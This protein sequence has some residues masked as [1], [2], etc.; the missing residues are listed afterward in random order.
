MKKLIALTTTLLMTFGTLGS[1][2]FAADSADVYVTISDKDGNLAMAQEKITVTDTDGDGALT[3]NDALHAAHEAKYDGGAAA[4]F[5]SSEGQYGLAIDR[6]WGSANG[7]S[8]G[9]YIN[10]KS[11]MGL[12]DAVNSGDYINA[13]VFTDL[14]AWSDTYCFFDTNTLNGNTNEDLALTLSAAG[15]DAGWNP[16]TLPVEGA[17]IYVNGKATEYK[18]DSDGK[19]SIRLESA[20]SYVISAESDTQTLVPPVC[21][22]TVTADGSDATPNTGISTAAFALMTASVL[23]FGFASSKSR[24]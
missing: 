13:Y 6:L 1:T 17:V 14:A 21:V 2:V 5:A 4:G 10:N 7:S 9:Y 22:A 20:G 16:V 15:Y 8:Y 19:V 12:A 24:K 23:A 11:A 18:T 3:I